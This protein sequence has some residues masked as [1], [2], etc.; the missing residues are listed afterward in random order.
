[1]GTELA[2][3]WLAN[4]LGFTIRQV[5][6]ELL[7]SVVPATELHLWV[8]KGRTWAILHPGDAIAREADWSGYYPI[9]ADVLAATF[10]VPA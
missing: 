5:S 7:T 3:R 4:E 2:R 10:E 9:A 1:M 8:A 6:T